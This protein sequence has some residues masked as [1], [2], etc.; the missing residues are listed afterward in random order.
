ME[1]MDL[2]T[3]KEVS[4]LLH[5]SVGSLANLRVQGG[6]IPFYK[7]GGAI[8]YSRKQILEYLKKSERRSTASYALSGGDNSNSGGKD[9]E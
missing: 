5:I 3:P 2:M 4:Q 1:D 7:V 8:R 6:F 9:D